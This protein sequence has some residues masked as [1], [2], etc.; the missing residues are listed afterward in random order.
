MSPLHFSAIK[1]NFLSLRL[2][3]HSPYLQNL[4]LS[5]YSFLLAIS[6]PHHSTWVKTW[7]F[8]Y[9]TH[10]EQCFSSKNTVRQS[11]L[12]LAAASPLPSFLPL[13]QSSYA[14]EKCLLSC[15]LFK[16][17]KAHFFLSKQPLTSQCDP[18][19]NGSFSD[20]RYFRVV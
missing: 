14:E 17:I 12:S 7:K 1:T 19:A 16:Y 8:Q 20:F 13:S 5:F 4:P 11:L 15:L 6:I 3:S 10:H 2:I 18:A 9:K